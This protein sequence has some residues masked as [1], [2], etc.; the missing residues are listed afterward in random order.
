EI[1]KAYIALKK[2]EKAESVLVAAEST[3]DRIGD[4][5][6][7][8]RALSQIC[9]SYESTGRSVQALYLIRRVEDLAVRIQLLLAIP[10]AGPSD[11]GLDQR[12]RGLLRDMAQK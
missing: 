6:L 5:A 4:P 7:R 9:Q 11:P 12:R 10:T 1:A 8:I 3:V 2:P